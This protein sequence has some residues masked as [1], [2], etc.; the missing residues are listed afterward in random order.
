MK[1]LFWV[2]FVIGL[3]LIL[4]NTASADPPANDDCV[5][6]DDAGTLVSDSTVQLSGSLIEATQDCMNNYYAEVWVKFTLTDCMDVTIDFCN[7]SID[8]MEFSD[9]V[10]GECPC[11]DMTYRSVQNYCSSNYNS[12]LTWYGLSAG[13]Y[14][15]SIWSTGSSDSYVVNITGTDCPEAPVNDDC[16]NATAVGEVTELAY[17]TRG[18][19]FDGEG[20]CM[21]SPNIWYVYTPTFTG[22]IRVTADANYGPRIA[23]YNGADCS[24]I[25]SEIGCSPEGILSFAATLGNQYL[26]EVGGIGSNNGD[27]LL[28]IEEAPESPDNDNCADADDAGTLSDGI[29]VQLTGTLAEAT[30]DCPSLYYP[31]VWVMFTVPDYMHVTIDFCDHPSGVDM[32][33]VAMGLYIDCPCGDDI[34]YTQFDNCGNGNPSMT[35]QYLPAGTYY[36]PILSSYYID[37]AYT[38]NIVGSL[39]STPPTGACCV[40]DSMTCEVVDE[41]TCM[42]VIDGSWKG[43]GTDCGTYDEETGWSGCVDV[44]PT[45]VCCYDGGFNC[46]EGVTFDDCYEVFFGEWRGEGTT[47]GLPDSTGIYE[48]CQSSTPTTG[49]CCYDDGYSCADGVT[50]SDCYEFYMGDYKGNGTYCGEID[51]VSGMYEAC[52]EQLPGACCFNDGM[53]CEIVSSELE[54]IDMYGGTWKGEG[55]TC[56]EY[57]SV[58]GWS[59]CIEPPV[60]ACCLEGGTICL[61]DASEFDCV[62]D[63]MGTWMGEGSVCGNIDPV[64]GEYEGCQVNDAYEYL[65]GDANMAAGSWPPNVIGAD[66]TYLVNYFRAIAAPCLVG[67]FYNSADANGDC[68]VIGADVTYLVQY[69]RGAN[70][71]HFCPDYEP[72]WQSSGDLPA[73]APDGWPNCE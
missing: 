7:N 54:C 11:G 72:T 40:S 8:V 38:V 47:C 36:Y 60:G 24:P 52:I 14:Y 56:G 22:N 57:D 68:S 41:Y 28:T 27:G 32:Y 48:G 37:D 12:A 5:N 69:F 55:S 18:A 39:S 16:T 33:S 64:S 61:N 71:L 6:A 15:Y 21:D 3:C 65:P 53:N 67:G 50:E 13:T 58:E 44:E 25:S 59:G 63:Y 70:E 23:V 4:N 2:V 30:I 31:E 73:E 66:V 20:Y 26:I 10:F 34:N 35:W 43:E 19:S 29:P 17:S 62:N 49:A 1:K 46:A 42:Y 51:P 45:G 9:Y